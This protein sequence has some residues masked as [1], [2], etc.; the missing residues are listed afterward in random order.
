[1]STHAPYHH[2]WTSD[3]RKVA[4][5][6]NF[7]SA[8]EPSSEEPSSEEEEEVESVLGPTLSATAILFFVAK[9]MDCP[10]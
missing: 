6:P 7:L 8:L 3:L 4:A 2:H 1:M 5:A 9:T 10:S